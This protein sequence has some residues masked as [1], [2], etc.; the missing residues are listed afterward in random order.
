[1]I[2]VLL[3]ILGYNQR[4]S[5]C[6]IREALLPTKKPLF[7]KQQIQS[8]ASSKLAL[9]SQYATTVTTDILTGF[10]TTCARHPGERILVRR[11]YSRR[12][13][14]PSREWLAKQ[15]QI[16]LQNLTTEPRKQQQQLQGQGQNGAA[17]SSPDVTALLQLRRQISAYQ[18]DCKGTIAIPCA[19]SYA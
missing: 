16:E 10:E 7:V 13:E 8:F 12:V 3:Q 2:S 11:S 17:E 1:M 9:T 14:G 4:S 18:V 5:S 15:L 6:S 19:V